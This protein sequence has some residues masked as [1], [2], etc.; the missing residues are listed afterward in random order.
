MTLVRLDD[1]G[2]I[3]VRFSARLK[4]LEPSFRRHE[5]LDTVLEDVRAREVRDELEEHLRQ[6]PLHGFHC[7]REPAAGYFQ[8]N[9]LRL[10]GLA[11]HQAEFLRNWGHLFTAQER[12]DIESAWAAHFVGRA[13]TEGR[14]GKI[15]FCLTE[16]T[17]RSPGTEVF[18]KHFGGEAVFM[19]LKRH[20]TVAAK[21]GQ[22]GRP[23]IVEARLEP[24]TLARLPLAEALLSA[25]HQTVR[26]SA[27]I[28]EAETYVCSPVSPRD[29]LAV[30]TVQAR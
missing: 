19:P 17:A 30:T 21:L 16:A 12:A 8:A 15:W 27:R 18:F 11:S 3:P 2:G 14:N 7:C 26:P 10:T 1:A 25:H 23:V 9:G 13:Q 6:V 4:A 20:P 22:I 5:H 24:G 28:R 29:V